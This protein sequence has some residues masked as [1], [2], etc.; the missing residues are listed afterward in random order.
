MQETAS[1]ATGTAAATAAVADP[2]I[3]DLGKVKKKQVKR[4]K[5]GGGPLVEE[6]ADVVE[7]VREELGADA[8]GTTLV[9]VVIVYRQ[10][11]KRKKLGS[12][13]RL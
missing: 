8:A 4:L 10:K 12:L 5:E 7:Q 3:V 2:V 6:I 13:L 11:P 1:P 9:P